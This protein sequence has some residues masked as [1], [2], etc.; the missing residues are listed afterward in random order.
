[1]AGQVLSFDGDATDAYAE[2]ATTR[3]RAGKPIGQF[4][5]MIAAIPWST[6]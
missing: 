6:H 4:Y 5:A 3:K 2:I 1:M